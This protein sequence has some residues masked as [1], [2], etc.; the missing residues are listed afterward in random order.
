MA[1]MHQNIKGGVK[2]DDSSSPHGI[3]VSCEAVPVESMR[4]R[5]VEKVVEER[6]A[7]GRETVGALVKLTCEHLRA[8][9]V[10][11]SEACDGI[12]HSR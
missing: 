11:E 10:T 5:A 7:V 8:A 1:D 9:G 6:V 4:G 3:A 12:R 2:H